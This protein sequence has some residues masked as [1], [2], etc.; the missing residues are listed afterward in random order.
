MPQDEQTDPVWQEAYQIDG[1]AFRE[2]WVAI[3][4]QNPLMPRDVMMPWRGKGKFNQVVRNTQDYLKLVAQNATKGDMWVGMYPTTLYTTNTLYRLYGDV[5]SPDLQ[6]ALVRARRMEEAIRTELGVQ[7]ATLFSAGK[8]FH[9]HIEHDPIQGNGHAY[10][11]AVMQTLDGYGAYF[12]PG[13]LKNRNAKPRIPY[14]FNSGSF[15]KQGEALYCVPVDLT[16][17]LEAIK[18]ASRHLISTPFKVPHSKD[19]AGILAPLVKRSMDGLKHLKAKGV[20]DERRKIL[21]T[22]AIRFSETD[23]IM[24]HNI[25]GGKD[26]RRRVLFSL[27]IP[28][29]MNEE[30]G[31]LQAV[32]GRT[33][34]WV[35][36]SGERWGLYERFAQ[37]TAR[38]C[39]LP[40]GSVRMPMG[41]PRWF[42]ENSDL[43]INKPVGK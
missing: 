8:G 35:D 37:E 23:G 38:Q 7:P 30:D 10:E 33:R 26:G 20:S 16:W 42:A 13:P 17:D 34:D 32:M 25:K 1:R 39:V 22:Q 36:R 21:V 4:G 15:A 19:A 6:D 18:D 14:T 3:L 24:L 9:L 27:L 2:A 41:L 28:A 31:D 40:D 12:D 11:E 29:L 43:K 5:D